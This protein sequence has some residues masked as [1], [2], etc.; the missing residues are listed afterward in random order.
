MGSR[1]FDPE[2]VFV[3]NAGKRVGQAR[4]FA[5]PTCTHSDPAVCS[6]DLQDFYSL[7]AAQ[8]FLK[9]HGAGARCPAT[10]LP[11]AKVQEVPSITKDSR[12]KTIG[13]KDSLHWIHMR[14]Q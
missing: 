13:R 3:D 2:A 12:I 7:D 4:C 10:N 8:A 9:R 1:Y 6:G 5:V 11:V 14:L